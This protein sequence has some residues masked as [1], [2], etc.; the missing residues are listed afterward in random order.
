MVVLKGN[1]VWRA[2]LQS[3]VAVVQAVAVLLVGDVAGC[4]CTQP[5]APRARLEMGSM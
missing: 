2:E 4:P 5:G 1:C 3:T